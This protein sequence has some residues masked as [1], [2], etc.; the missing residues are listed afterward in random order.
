MSRRALAWLSAGLLVLSACSPVKPGSSADAGAPAAAPQAE[1]PYLWLEDVGADTA[2]DWVRGRNAQAKAAIESDGGFA[3]LE[4]DL[5]A[6][7][8]SD[9]KIPFVY[10]QGGYVYNFWTDRNNQRGIWRRTTLAEYRKAEP[11][12]ETLIDVDALNAQEGENWVWH[13]ASCRGRRT[14]ASR[15]G[16]AWFRC[17]AA[18]P[19]PM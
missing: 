17:R 4:N 16:A 15:T 13:G 19:T 5:L 3:A 2:L 18:V 6:I 8:D 12:W 10:K 14:R 1:D 9:E 11:A 7:L